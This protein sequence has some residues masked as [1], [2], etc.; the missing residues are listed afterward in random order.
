MATMARL[1]VLGVVGVAAVNA[2][3]HVPLAHRPKTL[4]EFHTASQRR[5]KLA[6]RLGAAEDPSAVRLTDLE[7]SEYYGE[8]QIGN[9]PQKFQVIYDTGSSNLWVPSKACTNCKAGSPRYDSSKP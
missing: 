5:A 7:D 1:A 9:P 3:I 2:V 6:A 8:V 4:S